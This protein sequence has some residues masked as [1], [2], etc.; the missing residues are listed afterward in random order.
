MSRRIAVFA[1]GNGSNLQAIIDAIA[2]NILRAE[3][4]VVVSDATAARALQRAAAA[5]VPTLSLPPAPQDSREDYA[6]RLVTALAPYHIDLICL[7]GFMR[8]IAAP[9]LT[10]YPHRIINIHPALLP[11]YPGLNAISRAFADRVPE[12]G[13]TVHYVDDGIDTGPIIAQSRVAVMPM[14][15]VASLTERIHAAEHDLYPRTIQKV[16]DQIAAS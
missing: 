16:L 2:A 8:L 12:T 6:W 9:L 4:A 5:Q 11:L 10:A 14:D 3:L 7:A 1:S 15:S 13:C